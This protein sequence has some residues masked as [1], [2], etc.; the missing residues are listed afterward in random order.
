MPHQDR[1]ATYHLLG[2]GIL[3]GFRTLKT[4]VQAVGLTRGDF[5]SA[6]CRFFNGFH[7]SGL[8]KAKLFQSCPINPVFPGQQ[9]RIHL[10]N[11]PPQKLTAFHHFKSDFQ[12]LMAHG[13]VLVRA[14]NRQDPMEG[15]A[16]ALEGDARVTHAHAL[17]GLGAHTQR[18]GVKDLF[19]LIEQYQT[20]I[21]HT[22]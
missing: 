2:N 5:I 11:Q 12:P 8:F 20:G 18:V 19:F 4:D 1:M 22:F 17:Y 15:I 7:K 16:V 6:G 3:V 10:E 14:V 21:G 9:F 13:M